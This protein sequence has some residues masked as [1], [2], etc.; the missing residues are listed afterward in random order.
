MFSRSDRLLVLVDGLDLEEA[1]IRIGFHV[2]PTAFRRL[3]A[4]SARL[5]RII[6]AVTRGRDAPAVSP[7]VDDGISVVHARHPGVALA[8]E[9]LA[10]APSI[11]HAVLCAS[12]ADYVPLVKALGRRGIPVTLVSTRQSATAQAMAPLRRAASHFIELADM[13]D[14]V[15]LSPAPS[16]G[17]QPP[18]AVGVSTAVLHR[19]TRLAGR[20]RGSDGRPPASPGTAAG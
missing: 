5:L 8:V 3:F 17:S 11:D 4:S 10:L 20:R 1:A 9:A 2:D 12:D 7:R 14:R 13:R 18:S 6:W 15:S 19:G 16:V